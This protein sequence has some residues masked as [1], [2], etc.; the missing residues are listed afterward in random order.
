M[1][2]SISWDVHIGFTQNAGFVEDVIFEFL[3]IE[4]IVGSVDSVFM[5]LFVWL[6]NSA[7]FNSIIQPLF[8]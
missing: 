5:F 1:I 8:S 4:L 2:K 7:T 3:F 6:F